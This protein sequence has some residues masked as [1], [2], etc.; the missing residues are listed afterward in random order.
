[1]SE[2]RS[3][4]TLPSIIAKLSSRVRTLEIQNAGLPVFTTATKP[5]ATTVQAGTMIFVSD[6]GAG[7]KFQGSDGSSWVSLG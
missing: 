3:S 2:N 6:A 7:S 5:G 4:P 1:M